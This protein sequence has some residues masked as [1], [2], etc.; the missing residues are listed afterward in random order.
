MGGFAEMQNTRIVIRL[1]PGLYSL[2]TESTRFKALVPKG[3]KITILVEH[4]TFPQRRGL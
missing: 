4:F 2:Y 3:L 1:V